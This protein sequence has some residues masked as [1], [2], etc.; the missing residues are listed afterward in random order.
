MG[1]DVKMTQRFYLSGFLLLTAILSGWLVWHYVVDFQWEAPANPHNPD[2]FVNHLQVIVMN[3]E[4][5]RAYQFTS[6]HML[7]YAEGDR[8]T[9]TLPYLIIYENNEPP[10]TL[11]AKQGEALQGH[12]QVK[13]WGDVSMAQ[14]KGINN[15]PTM[16]KTEEAMIYPEQHIVTTDK[17]ISA[18]QPNANA[19]GVGMKLDLAHKTLDMLSQVRGVYVQAKK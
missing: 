9:F 2:A 18:V 14:P 8:T 6:P 10:W 5:S 15:P 1:R 12:T 16:I 17:Y 7:H 3:A 13:L 19:E 11:Q 4:G